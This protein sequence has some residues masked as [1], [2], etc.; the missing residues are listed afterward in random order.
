M[1]MHISDEKQH[2]TLAN[3]ERPAAVAESIT[4]TNQTQF[5]TSNSNC[6]L[7]CLFRAHKVWRVGVFLVHSYVI[8]YPASDLFAVI[9]L[10]DKP[11]L[12]VLSTN[13]T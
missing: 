8:K 5:Q 6:R 4:G 13:A 7:M 1:E 12:L 3:K 2:A 11:K 10:L 9:I